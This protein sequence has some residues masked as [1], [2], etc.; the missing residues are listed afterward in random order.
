MN[1]VEKTICRN[2]GI[3]ETDYLKTRN[4]EHAE[5]NQSQILNDPEREVCANLG[6]SETE[7]LK[8]IYT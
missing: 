1:T 4:S 8:T 2:L 6:I 3:S 5:E 7:Y